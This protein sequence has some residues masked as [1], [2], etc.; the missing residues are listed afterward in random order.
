MGLSVVYG[1][2]KQHGGW[3]EVASP[4]GKGAEF[5]LYFPARPARREEA[6]TEAAAATGLAGSGQRILIVEDDE[7]VRSMAA[8]V[9]RDRGYTVFTAATAAEARKRF[10]EQHGGFDLVFCDIALP[11]DSGLR[12]A[13]ELH[14]ERPDLSVLLS[15]GYA[16]K[17]SQA[18]DLGKDFP[19]LE[20]PYALFDLLT[21]VKDSLGQ[22]VGTP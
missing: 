3:I 22:P 2:V 15:S 19:L 1:S 6:P 20:K 7:I 13:A 21:A 10:R 8:K 4:A 18:A 14:S 12:L 17:R 16:D 9:L 11:D 5:A